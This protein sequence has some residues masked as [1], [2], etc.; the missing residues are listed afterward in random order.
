MGYFPHLLS[1]FLVL[2]LLACQSRSF[3]VP[4]PQKIATAERAMVVS[5][6]PLAT[7]VGLDILQ[8]GGT[9][10]D[11]AIAVQ[12][13]LAVVYPRAGNIGGGGFMLI[14][15]ED[16]TTTSLD[17][18][19]KAPLAAT[20]DMYLDDQGEI[21]P[22]ASLD[23]IRSV[24]VPGTVAGLEAAYA[25][26]GSKS[27]FPWDQLLAPAV[28]L[29]DRGFAV[30]SAEAERLNE[31]LPKFLK[32]NTT[33][34]PFTEPEA[35]ET[36]RVLRQPEL[37]ETLRRIQAAGRDGFYQGETAA[38]LLAEMERQEGYITQA[39]L[40]SYE[41]VWRDP[42]LS[43][44]ENY[45]IASMPLPSSGG[46]VLGQ[47]VEMVKGLPLSQWGFQDIN[48]TH[49]MIEAM[50]RAYT[51]RARFMG[52]QDFYPVPVDSLLDPAYLKEKMASLRF[53][54]ATIST[55]LQAASFSVPI[56]SFE[57]TH[58]S[59]VDSMGNAVSVTTT[60]NANYGSKVWV[61]G[62]GFFLND[63]MDD[64]SSKPGTPNMFG[65]V[66]GEANAIEPGKRMLSSM[67][68]T[69]VLRD[70]EVYLVLGTPGGSTII[71]SVF[72]VFMN[73]AVFGLDLE[74]AVHA[75]RFHHQWLPDE[76]WIEEDR[77]YG[78]L[79]E[80]LQRLGHTVV[81]KK[82]IGAVKAIIRRSNG[83]WKGV[84]DIRQPDD[85]AAGY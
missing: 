78:S 59:I 5:P 1:G 45:Q 11:A 67:T 7:Q 12:F 31:H 30:S 8:Q 22:R 69:I 15:L 56:E 66:G 47:M 41:A 33:P 36:G 28:E 20:R 68:P 84:G 53:D 61:D 2:S 9:A 55:Q 3:P 29:A 64:F 79:P 73:V 74:E 49:T 18:R 13:A 81:E 58:T 24:G 62:A 17:Y 71:T 42:I 75:P 80:D 25:K 72:Q 70:G 32:H 10:L 38:A 54:S 60:L 21:I 82:R 46:I 43:E 26:Y 77:D 14:H 63:E 19:E 27:L 52:D 37:A 83:S 4:E 50:R 39:D 44:F 16:G 51:D 65:L 35:W 34:N 6:H 23:G 76:V 85:H 40:D 57:T 48:S